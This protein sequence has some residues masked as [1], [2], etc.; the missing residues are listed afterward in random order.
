M[1]TQRLT[2]HWHRCS[3]SVSTV[4]VQQS[5]SLAQ[6]L[7]CSV[8]IDSIWA[9]PTNSCILFQAA[10]GGTIRVQGIYEDINLQIPPGTPSHTR[11]KTIIWRGTDSRSSHSDYVKYYFY[12]IWRLTTILILCR[13]RMEKKGIKKVSGFGHGDHYINIKVVSNMMQRLQDLSP[14]AIQVRAPK[15]LDEKQRA[16]MQA[17]AELEPGKLVVI[18]LLQSIKLKYLSAQTRLAR[19]MVWPTSWVARK[20]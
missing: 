12:Q 18:V 19:F 13:M 17:Y 14:H 10:L 9:K 5:L 15:K 11:L 4:S 7:W 20:L 2:Y 8:H 1:C 6:M 3:A 16:L